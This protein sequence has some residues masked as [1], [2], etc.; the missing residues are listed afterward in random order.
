MLEQM[1]IFEQGPYLRNVNQRAL[2]GKRWVILQIGQDP[3]DQHSCPT[4]CRDSPLARDI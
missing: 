2:D 4:P 1:T 3:T